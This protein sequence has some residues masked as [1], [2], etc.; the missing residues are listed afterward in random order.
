MKRKYTLMSVNEACIRS[1]YRLVNLSFLNDKFEHFEISCVSE[2]F[3]NKKKF[4]VGEDYII[5]INCTTESLHEYNTKDNIL[6][7]KINGKALVDVDS[8][9]Y[10]YQLDNKYSNMEY[11]TEVNFQSNEKYRYNDMISIDIQK[12]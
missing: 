2:D 12:V 10:G 11:Y 9:V 3:Y 5:E 7:M 8:K 1:N 6:Y 4:D